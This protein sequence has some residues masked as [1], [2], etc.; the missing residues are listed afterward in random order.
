L[1]HCIVLAQAPGPG[2]PPQAAAHAREPAGARADK[3][4]YQIGPADILRV[5]VF[6][7]DDLTQ[8]VLL[9][10]DGTFNFPLVG[11][12]K[13]S[14]MTTAELE[15]KIAILLARGFIRNPQVT[16]VVQEFR[17]KTVYVVGEVRAP[18]P[19]PC[20]DEP[21]RSPGKGRPDQQRRRRGG[22]R[23]PAPGRNGLRPRPPHRSGGG[24]GSAAGQ[25]EGRRLPRRDE[26]HAGR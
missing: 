12:V 23:A 18:D 26:R 20:P 24:R 9:Q 7:H 21:R 8:T 6:G 3:E 1:P 25:T 16:V 22:G 2:A 14:D 4:D 10:P 15:K 19:I 17:S 11:R 13:G 5:T